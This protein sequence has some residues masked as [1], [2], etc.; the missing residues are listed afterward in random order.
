MDQKKGQQ[1]EAVDYKTD[2]CLISAFKKVSY[3]KK[4]QQKSCYVSSFPF[5]GHSFIIEDGSEVQPPIE[6]KLQNQE[7]MIENIERAALEQVGI[8]KEVAENPFVFL[9][10]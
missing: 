1:Y 9:M 2:D 7:A 8:D 10:H 6:D 4:P 5:S 3:A